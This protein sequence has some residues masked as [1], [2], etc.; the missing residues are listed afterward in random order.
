MNPFPTYYRILDA[1]CNRAAE[2]LR[3]IEDICRFVFNAESFTKQLKTLRHRLIDTINHID[4]TGNQLIANRDSES[5]IGETILPELETNRADA[6]ALL[7]ANFRRAQEAVRVLE[8]TSKLIP[9][10]T[11]TTFKTIR[12]DLYR[13]EKEIFTQFS[14]PIYQNVDLYVVTDPALSKGRAVEEVVTA[15]IA[16]GATA[17]QLRDKD[18]GTKELFEQGLRLRQITRNKS[19]RRNVNNSDTVLLII[20]DRVDIAIAVDAD[21]VHLG[22]TDMP[23]SAARKIL[24]YDKIIGISVSSLEQAIAAEQSGA[25]Y[26]GLSPIFTTPTKPDAGTGLGLKFIRQVKRKVKIPLVAIGGINL[27]NIAEIIQAG[28]DSAAVVSAVVS[29]NNIEKAAKDLVTKIR[30]VK[31]FHKST[32]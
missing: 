31:D 27:D 4:S 15:A 24:G 17:I 18:A 10:K 21:G 6:Y 3:V 7:V 5:D 9:S 30:K 12:F 14:K 11:S 1:N 2:G 8:E 32:K 29:A 16:G 13:L 20:N 28:A 26:L 22:Q 25:D 19:I 23:I